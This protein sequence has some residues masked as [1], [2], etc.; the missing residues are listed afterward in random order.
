MTPRQR[1]LAVMQGRTPDHVPAVADLSWWLAAERREKFVPA[2]A[3]NE[4]RI[5][6][7]L[8]LHRR[9]NVAIHLNLGVF[10]RIRHRSDVNITTDVRD[11]EFH[12]RIQ[13]PVGSVQELRRWSDASWSWGIER[14]MIHSVADLKVIRYAYE[15]VTVDCD[16]A[17]FE[18]IDA[19]VGDIGVTFLPLPYSGMGY[20]IS[21]Y[22][23]VEQTVLM[24]AD[25]PDQLQQTLD[26][27]NAAHLRVVR[28]MVEGPGQVLFHSDNLSSDVQSPAWFARYSAEHYRR[29]AQIAHEHGKVI[30]VHIDGRLR[31]LLKAVN[32]CGIDAAD[33]VT[34]A[35]WGDLT[36]QQCREEAGR[37]LVLSGGVPP[38]SFMPQVAM[39]RFD[40][41]VEAW[42]ALRHPSAALVIAPG[43][44]LPPAASLQRVQR[45]VEAA[46]GAKY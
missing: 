28:A 36:P 2:Q 31:G 27:L 18:Q 29:M 22:A 26:V 13:T 3:G 46:S 39:S 6:Q 8:E 7:L 21:R 42:L 23:G 17:R 25:E 30:S 43:D 4:Q 35:P 32:D 44:Q 24:A 41:Q 11:D 19:M 34:P 38:D 16:R 10:Y 33:A 9:L 14:H 45:M 37:R 20:L 15:D 1:L 40:E 12:Y 5:A